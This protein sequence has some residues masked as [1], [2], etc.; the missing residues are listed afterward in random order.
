MRTLPFVL[1]MLA[2]LPGA[3]FAEEG[4]AQ[5]PRPPE[6]EIFLP[7]VGKINCNDPYPLD[8][9][10]WEIAPGYSFT[11]VEGAY[12][13]AGATSTVPFTRQHGWFT[14]VTYG[15]DDGIDVTMTLGDVHGR[16]DGDDPNG[17]GIPGPLAGQGLGDTTLGARWQFYQSE[18][19]TSA[20]A[21]MSYL[22]IPTGPCA[23]ETRFGLSQEL[24]SLNP[25]LAVAKSWGRFVGI[26]DVGVNVPLG[27]NRF[28]ARGGLSANLAAGYQIGD[29]LKPIVEL[30]Y[31]SYYYGGAPASETLGV[32]GGLLFM[33][34]DEVTLNLGITRSIAGRNAPETTSGVFFLTI[35]P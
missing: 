26:A 14:Q 35:S 13:D 25:R 3:A 30:N 2:L 28:D 15:V 29:S 17:F 6:H 34:S 5:A 31:N 11:S 20:A 33:L 27:A 24:W 19:Q 21:V 1:M 16:A 23:T 22:T 18:D 7:E 10:T 9:G 4:D 32:T 8:P 12:D